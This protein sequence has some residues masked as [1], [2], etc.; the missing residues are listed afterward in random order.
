MVDR[1]EPSPIAFP[2]VVYDAGGTPLRI[3]R[4]LKGMKCQAC[5]Y[6]VDLGQLVK[7][8][9]SYTLLCPHCGDVVNKPAYEVNEVL[10]AFADRERLLVAQKVAERETLMAAAAQDDA[11]LAVMAAKAPKRKVAKKARKAKTV[12]TK[13]KNARRK[14]R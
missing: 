14:G 5:P 4:V 11:A 7:T 3:E 8:E 1:N 13:R 10:A 6:D 2:H 9:N 12:V